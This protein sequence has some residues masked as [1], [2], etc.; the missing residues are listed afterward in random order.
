MRSISSVRVASSEAMRSAASAF[1]RAMR[2]VSVD[3]RGGDLFLVDGA[4]ARDLAAADFLLQ[5]D[6][7]VGD[8][9]LLRDA[10]ALGGFA[11]RDFGLL[12]IA[13][14][15][16]FEPAVLFFL[17][18]AGARDREFL[19]D[20]RLFGLLARGDLGMLDVALAARSRAAGRLPRGR[21]ARR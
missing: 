1:S 4:V 6:A 17:G 8:D 5:R 21:C 13:G 15:L 20:T 9:A 11:R 14:A 18:N 16:D 2:A 10:C 7:L 3:L 19:G 12:Q